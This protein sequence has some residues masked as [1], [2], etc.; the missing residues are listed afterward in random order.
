MIF[1]AVVAS[2]SSWRPTLSEIERGCNLN[3]TNCVQI[4]PATSL[5]CYLSQKD[6]YFDVA[7][8]KRTLHSCHVVVGPNLLPENQFNLRSTVQFPAR[9]GGEPAGQ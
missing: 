4:I 1:P 5:A 8:T 6:D 2:S 9:V 7:V 3:V